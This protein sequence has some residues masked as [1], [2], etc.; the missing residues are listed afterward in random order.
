MQRNDL[1]P[2]FSLPDQNGNALTLSTQLDEGP[3]VLFFYPAAMT[4]GCTK[5]SRNFRDLG[6]KFAALGAQRIGISMDSVARQCQFG[7]KNRLDYPLLSDETG[8]VATKYGVKRALKLLKVRRSTFVIDRDRHI[9]DIIN[10]EV[11]MDAHA[12]R[13]LKALESLTL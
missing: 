6:A 2:D 11:N 12:Q 4:A 8:E 3:V 7:Q 1:A 10:N 13:A 9:V 5:E